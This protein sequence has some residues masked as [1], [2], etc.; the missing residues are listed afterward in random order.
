[1]PSKRTTKLYGKLFYHNAGQAM[2]IATVFFLAVAISIMFGTATPVL[3]QGKITENFVSSRQSYATSESGVEDVLYRLKNGKQ[4]GTTEVLSVAGF[5]A[6]TTTTDVGSNQKQVT[7]EGNYSNKIRKSQADVTASS[8][9]TFNYGV[10]VGAGGLSMTQ[11]SGVIGNVYSNGKISGANSNSINGTAISAG[12]E[13]SISGTHI[14]GSAYANEIKNSWVGQDAYYD[15]ELE[16]TT[17]IGNSY[18]HSTDKPAIPLPIS[19]TLI[20]QWESDAAAGGTVSSPCPYKI[21]NNT[22]IG[23]IKISCD[24]E[25]SGSPPFTVTLM[26]PI[27]VTGNITLSNTI[28]FSV[29]SSLGNKSVSI[30]ADNPSNKITSSKIKL[31]NS[32]SYLGNGNS[33]SKVLLLSQNNSTETGG[34]VD[35]IQVKNTAGGDLLVYAGHGN[36][37]V[38]NNTSLKQVTGYKVTTKNTAQV[39]FNL[40]LP[41]L[42]FSSGPSGSFTVSGWREVQ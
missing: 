31:Q 24:L 3:R 22:T 11:S 17:V 20:S 10:Q 13:G 9:V 35:A 15:H 37:S 34:T 26:G 4:V 29:S 6:T 25:I 5:T 12:S 14:T 27:W 40:G 19:D 32:T 16:N 7:A 42:L 30:I 18:D 23:P 36:I 41:S 28:A 39:T 2:L 21:T 33:G 38:E 1:M 8:G